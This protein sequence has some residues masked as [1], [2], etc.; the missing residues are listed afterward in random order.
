MKKGLMFKIINRY[1]LREIVVPFF[2]ILAVLTFVLLMGKILQVMDLMVNKGI[3]FLDIFRLIIYLIPGF[4][5]Y[6]V[7][8]SLLIAI[9]IGVGRLSG[10]NEWTVLR[11][12]G[13]SLLQ[14]SRPVA[15][16]AFAAFLIT[17][18]TTLFLVPKGNL[19]SRS[20]LFEIARSGAGIGIHEKV[21]IDYFKDILLYADRIPAQG[22]FLEGIFISDNH[23]GKEANTVIARR[24]YLISDPDK[25]Y[26]TLRLEDGS[27]HTVDANLN[28]YR[29]ADFR[30]YD[31]KLEIGAT[32]AGEEGKR[33]SSTE[34]TF[35]ELKRM[36]ND[37]SLKDVEIRELLIELNKKLAIPLSCL[38]FP[39]LG[40]PLGMRAH[41]SVRARGFI[42]G[43][44]LVMIYY[45]LRLIGEGLV[46]SGKI[47]PFVGVWTPNAI[48]AVAGALLFFNSAREKTLLKFL[49]TRRTKA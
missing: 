48:F 2:M 5:V 8:I 46:E 37:R 3:S 44:F 40:I 7:P 33:K 43:V 6:T 21:F 9:L 20:L 26:I 34:M 15:R 25:R 29:K 1:I 31:M 30:F 49:R 16:V 39:L 18:A 24:A 28:T 38:I 41:R 12:S 11:M 10:D 14:L 17:L 47:A 36:V 32:I 35:P 19:A 27:T 42:A 22:D 45:L 13:L 23:L 4:L